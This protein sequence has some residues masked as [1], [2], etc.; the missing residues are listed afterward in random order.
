MKSSSNKPSLVAT[1]WPW[2]WL[3]VALTAYVAQFSPLFAPILQTLGL[4]SVLRMDAL[5]PIL[6]LLGVNP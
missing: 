3:A 4:G 1:V 2:A 5:R 6:Q